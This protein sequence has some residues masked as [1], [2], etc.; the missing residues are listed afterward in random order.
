METRKLVGFEDVQILSREDLLKII[1]ELVFKLRY[2]I[3]FGRFSKIDIERLRIKYDRMFVEVLRVYN[4]ILKDAE[5]EEL[6]KRVE[7]LERRLI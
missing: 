4:E 6:R 5:I 7:V 1:T 3:F 2:K